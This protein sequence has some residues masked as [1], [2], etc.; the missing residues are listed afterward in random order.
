MP[1][2]DLLFIAPALGAQQGAAWTWHHLLHDLVR[3]GGESGVQRL[4]A[5]L[6]EHRHAEVEVMRQAGFAIYAQDRLYCLKQ[7]PATIS[8]TDSSSSGALKA[9]QWKAHKSVDDWGLSRLYHAL[10]PVVVQQAESMFHDGAREGYGGWWGSTRRGCYVL[11]GQSE[12][13][14]LGYLRLTKGEHGHWLKMVL[15]P[16]MAT[17]SHHLLL[18]GLR[19][20]DGWPRR[21]VY[22]DVREYEGYITEGLHKS[23]FELIMTRMLLVRHTTASIRI[24]A[25]TPI[26]VLESS[27]ET[28]PTPF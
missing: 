14:V 18:A 7:P 20:M 13:E 10:T 23:G 15:H 24:K 3:V 2:L 17:E 5:H 28:A 27:V 11:Q 22:C 4:F 19:L 9:A 12:G 16:Q 25:A 8:G 21:P 6:P 1:A 26:R